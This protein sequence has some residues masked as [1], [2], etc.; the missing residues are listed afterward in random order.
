MLRIIQGERPQK[1][2]FVITRGYTEDLWEITTRCWD[3]KPLERP[4]VDDLLKALKSA[5]KQWE[6]TLSFSPQD[7][8]SPTLYADEFNLCTPSEHEDGDATTGLSTSPPVLP[9]S[10]TKNETS[11]EHVPGGPPVERS[12]IPTTLEKQHTQEV[13]A[14]LPETQLG[15]PTLTVSRKDEIEVTMPGV[16][17]NSPSVLG[18]TAP[19]SSRLPVDSGIPS[20]LQPG[21]TNRTS[22]LPQPFKD[23]QQ[24]LQRLVSGSAPRDELSSLIETVVSNVRADAVVDRGL[25]GIDAQT[26]VDVLDQVCL[27]S[28]HRRGVDSL[29]ST[30]HSGARR[31]RFST[32]NPQRMCEVAVHHVCRA[33][34]ASQVDVLRIAWGYSW[35]CTVPGRIRDR[36]EAWISWSGGCSQDFAWS[37]LGENVKGEPSL[38]GPNSCAFGESTTLFVE[39]LEGSHNLES[40]ATS[41]RLAT[42]RGGHDQG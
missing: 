10:M 32:R 26:F 36:F 29:L 14:S 40:R 21:D 4:I 5:A 33:H 39:I 38:V 8:L 9:P 25:Q 13:P 1:P 18:L 12:Q 16:K 27:S 28:F 31:P 24:A 42:R 34:P 41:K 6:P 11:L 3:E 2:I 20:Q 17:A 7:V 30:L 35:R 19:T 15:K 37:Q 22:K 23:G